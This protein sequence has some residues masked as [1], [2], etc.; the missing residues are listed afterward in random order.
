VCFCLR[1]H[2]TSGFPFAVFPREARKNGKPKEES[3]ALPEV[4]AMPT[5]QVV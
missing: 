1:Q 4:K 2:G 5:A 3:T